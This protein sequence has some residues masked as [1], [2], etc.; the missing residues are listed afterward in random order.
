MGLF[1]KDKTP[2]RIYTS[3]IKTLDVL[4][5]SLEYKGRDKYRARVVVGGDIRKTDGYSIELMFEKDS[6]SELGVLYREGIGDYIEELMLSLYKGL[7]HAQQK[8]REVR[9]DIEDFGKLKKYPDD[10]FRRSYFR[11]YS[12]KK[13]ARLIPKKN[14]ELKRKD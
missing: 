2:E 8:K 3:E 1:K 12:F 9:L 13:C 14:L 6:K 4:I 11:I 10:D 7:C 5:L